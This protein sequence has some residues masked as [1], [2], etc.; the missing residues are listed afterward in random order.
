MGDAGSLALRLGL[1]SSAFSEASK[2]LTINSSERGWPV[3]E[4]REKGHCEEQRKV[5]V[6]NG[7]R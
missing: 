4:G 2:Y 6:E 3:V 5:A 7:G 1:Y